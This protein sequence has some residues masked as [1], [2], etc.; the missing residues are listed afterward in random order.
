MEVLS[1]QIAE[2]DQ[3]LWLEFIKRDI[4]QWETYNLPDKTNNWYDFYC[5][6]REIVQRS[7]DADA[8]KMKNAIDGIKSER[9][10]LTP[11]IISGPKS[12]RL[13]GMRPTTRQRYVSYDR[14]MG[15]I[16]PTF[17]KPTSSDPTSW[18]FH[19]PPVP[20][21]ELVSPA[22]KKKATIFT[23]QRRNN[24]LAMPTKHLST[25][26][27]QI[28]QAPRS[29][30]EEHRRPAEQPASR[31]SDKGTQAPIAPGRSKQ[32]SSSASSHSVSDTRTPPLA[33]REA[34]LRALTSGKPMPPQGTSDAQKAPDSTRET[35][36]LAQKTTLKR[37]AVSPP[38]QT[39]SAHQSHPHSPPQSSNA[40]Q[41]DAATSASLLARPAVMRKRP[42]PD[43]FI[44]P[45]RKRV[46]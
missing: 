25:R 34:R 18:T 10:R 33:E 44:R 20:R 30:I 27:S 12:K 26:A 4:P 11:K 5:D 39:S 23:P 32:S 41:P 16:S 6:L 38:P 3:E 7:L 29:L 36:S 2:E 42:A 46:F 19:T 40:T 8:E 22:Q 1:P 9:A 45:K 43:V 31:R 15:G 35:L 21:S 17:N 24:T 14:K 37:P 28:K 13:P